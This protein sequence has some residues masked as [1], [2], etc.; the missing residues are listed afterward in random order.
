MTTITWTW[1]RL[2]DLSP[3]DV[4]DLLALRNEVFGLEQNCV[5]QDADGIDIA[6]WHLLGRDAS[7]TLAAYS[8]VVDAGAKFAEVSIGRV[9]TKAT[10]RGTG[11]GKILM[12]EGMQRCAHALGHQAIRISAQ[13]HLE[14]F[15][16]TF[17]FIRTSENYL[18]DGIP[19]VEMLYQ[20]AV[21]S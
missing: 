15:Y 10:H 1:A 21:N 14:A 13:A 16:N 3:R 9:V 8:R 6:A 7:G 12:R 4:Y 19:H 18:E 20:P 17:G 11:L 5:Y 2:D